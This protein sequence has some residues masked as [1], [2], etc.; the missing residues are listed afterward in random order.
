MKFL[1]HDKKFLWS[2][3]VGGRALSSFWWKMQTQYD[4]WM[5][6]NEYSSSNDAVLHVSNP[7][8]YSHGYF[9]H[10]PCTTT[11]KFSFESS[12]YIFAFCVLLIWSPERILE[13]SKVNA[14]C[15]NVKKVPFPYRHRSTGSVT[16]KLYS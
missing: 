16:A 10:A 1:G 6:M 9:S 7:L 2:K 11:V 15:C 5:I 14:Q 12:W 13:R 4:I 3:S 8:V